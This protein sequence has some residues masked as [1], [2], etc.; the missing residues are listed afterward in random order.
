MMRASK[1]K[2]NEI[3][4]RQ[5]QAETRVVEQSMKVLKRYSQAERR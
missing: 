5:S 2:R 1:R 4:R 3:V